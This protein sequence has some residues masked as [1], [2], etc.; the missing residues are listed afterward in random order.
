MCET[1]LLKPFIHSFTH[2]FSALPAW[3]KQEMPSRRW[4]ALW[5]G[6]AKVLRREGGPVGDSGEQLPAEADTCAASWKTGLTRS[7]WGGWRG[8]PCGW[9]SFCK[10]WRWARTGYAQGTTDC[11]ERLECRAKGCVGTDKT[12]TG[13]RSQTGKDLMNRDLVPAG[14]DVWNSIANTCRR[15]RS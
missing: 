10:T 14:R 4:W 11:S 12:R 2:Y 7:P 3:D 15:S 13:G 9:N 1:V 5:Q 6:L 8:F